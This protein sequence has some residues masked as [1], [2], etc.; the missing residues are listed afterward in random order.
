MSELRHISFSFSEIE[1][2][3]DYTFSNFKELRQLR[4]NH[5]NI[6]QIGPKTFAGL[7]KLEV[8]DLSGN[9]GIKISDG[10]FRDLPLLQELYIGE[11]NLQELDVNVFHGL[12][13]L[14]VLD[15]HGNSIKHLGELHM[16]LF[17]NLNVLDIS[18]NSLIALDEQVWEF[19]SKLQTLYIGGNSWECNCNMKIL[20]SHPS[21]RNITDAIICDG[22]SPLQYI[23]LSRVAGSDL[24]CQPPKIIDCDKIQ[25]H[26]KL[27][28]TLTMSC[29]I[30]GDPFPFIE[31]KTPRKSLLYP[32]NTTLGSL[33]VYENGSLHVMSTSLLDSG[34]WTLKISNS[35]GMVKRNFSV[36]VQ[37]TETTT[38]PPSTTDT[39]TRLHVTLTPSP[40]KLQATTVQKDK[41]P[42]TAGKH[43]TP[44]KP[45]S[46][47]P[48]S[49]TSQT[50]SA[51]T[52]SLKQIS[53]KMTPVISQP[54]QQPIP[55]FGQTDQGSTEAAWG[56][57]GIIVASVAGGCSLIPITSLLILLFK[58]ISAKKKVGTA[59]TEDTGST[60]HWRLES[61]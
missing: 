3:D 52:K 16:N 50:F 34:M 6:Q 14:K 60:S 37:A 20:K 4:L 38:N 56:S 44:R 5:N 46:A 24:K 51:K 58:Y 39:T 19:I 54:S 59:V 55:D 21:L 40:T 18:S 1:A 48:I 29:N 47:V 15:I 27:G 35:E 8:L 23:P 32:Y 2:L 41:K 45:T 49:S 22:P 12:T 13:R 30:T 10:T 33:S 9:L 25:T 31:W 36:D 17:P 26:I 43:S 61:V 7:S 57:T 53:I 42:Q 11:I 28:D